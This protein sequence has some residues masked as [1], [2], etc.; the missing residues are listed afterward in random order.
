MNY[1]QYT[2]Y[3]RDSILQSADTM[4]QIL[5]YG[6]IEDIQKMR[7]ELGDAILTKIFLE[8]PKKVYSPQTLNFIVHYIL[9]INDEIDERRYLKNSP[10]VIR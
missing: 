10:R 6:Q 8:N 1:K 4:H 7:Q 3:N 2:W 5:A 9:K